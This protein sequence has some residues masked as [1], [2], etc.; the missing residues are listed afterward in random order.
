MQRKAMPYLIQKQADGSTVK[1]WD[2]RD[3]PLT[4]GRGDKVDAQIDDIEMS[5]QHFVISPKGN[6]YVIQDQ[7]SRNGTLVNGQRVTETALKPNDDIRA[8]HTRFVFVE[9]L[10]TVI[11]K[12]QDEPKGYSTHIREISKKGKP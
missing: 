9:G 12:L 6:S 8:G 2:L 7:H 4:V 3:K 5:R 11:G 1:Q 10:A